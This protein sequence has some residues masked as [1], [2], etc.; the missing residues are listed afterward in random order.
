MLYL[1]F[2][3]KMKYIKSYIIVSLFL[4]FFVTC[5]KDEDLSKTELLTMK[6]WI[7]KSV[8]VSPAIEIQG[9][10]SFIE[11]IDYLYY[12]CEQDDLYIFKT[13]SIY[14]IEEGDSKCDPSS[15]VTL[16]MGNWS[17]NYNETTLTLVSNYYSYIIEK[18]LIELNKTEMN[19]Q[20]QSYFD[21]LQTTLYTL[22][23][24]YSH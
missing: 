2:T 18:Q 7:L 20:Y 4:I 19:L 5:K 12:P 22:N 1:L 11:I 3:E 14:S 9:Q 23:E 6:P 24:I 8:N 21:T 15:L 16:D 13:N 10:G 17:L